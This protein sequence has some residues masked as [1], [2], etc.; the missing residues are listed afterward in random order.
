MGN[1]STTPWEYA[2]LLQRPWEEKKIDSFIEWLKKRNYSNILETFMSS[3]EL[4][5]LQ[6]E[7]TNESF[8]SCELPATRIINLFEE[9]EQTI[10][11]SWKFSNGGFLAIR[12][13]DV[14]VT[15]AVSKIY[16]VRK[17]GTTSRQL[18]KAPALV[19]AYDHHNYARHFSYHWAWQ[20]RLPVTY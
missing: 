15:A 18:W 3:K 19:H 8:K 1:T 13:G 7:P 10:K 2:M 9:F 16:K 6:E 17:L 14:C 20:Q 11:K 4:K 5:K 12:T